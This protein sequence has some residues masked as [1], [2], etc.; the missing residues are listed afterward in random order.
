MEVNR[1]SASEPRN[2]FP[3]QYTPLPEGQPLNAQGPHTTTHVQTLDVDTV[4]TDA[5]IPRRRDKHTEDE[6][7]P[8]WTYSDL[9]MIAVP[10]V[11]QPPPDIMKDPTMDIQQRKSN[12][13]EM[14]DLEEDTD[15]GEDYG[16]SRDPDHPLTKKQ[17]EKAERVAAQH[18]IDLERRERR[19][20][21]R[22]PDTWGVIKTQQD[23]IEQNNSL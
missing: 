22:I 11:L 21:G 4:M 5:I 9:I 10:G 12:P 14:Y 2:P 7:P 1:P 6:G 16:P 17:R 18:K 19:R 20:T 3:T 8:S 15:Y 13:T 23:V